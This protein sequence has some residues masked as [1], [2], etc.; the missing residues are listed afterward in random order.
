MSV[1]KGGEIAP[2]WMQVDFSKLEPLEKAELVL[3]ASQRILADLEN[4][5]DDEGV[6]GDPEKVEEKLTEINR[7]RKILIDCGVSDQVPE[8]V[9]KIPTHGGDI[10]ALAEYLGPRVLQHTAVLPPDGRWPKDVKPSEKGDRSLPTPE[11]ILRM[12][13]T[14]SKGLFDPALFSKK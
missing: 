1:D 11:P 9:E 3:Q 10:P 5:L 14:T 4:L 6:R 7:L 13:V 12:F 8:G 2:S